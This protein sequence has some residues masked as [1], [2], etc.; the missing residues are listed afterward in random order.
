MMAYGSR[1]PSR[2]DLRL[3]LSKAYPKM[4]SRYLTQFITLRRPGD[5]IYKH[6]TSTLSLRSASIY[7]YSQSTR[8]P[9]LACV[10]AGLILPLAYT[11]S[12]NLS[13]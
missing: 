2:A 1:G 8:T 7:V 5:P 6:S 10:L 4:L 12:L 13:H 3:I 11:A 9:L